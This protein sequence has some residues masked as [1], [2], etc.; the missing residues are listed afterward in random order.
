MNCV[1]TVVIHTYCFKSIINT[2]PYLGRLNAHI[3]EG[4]CAV[5]LNY[6]CNYLIIGVLEHHTHLLP[7]IEQPALIGSVYAVNISLALFGKVYSIKALGKGRFAR[8]VMPE[9][10]HELTFFDVKVNAL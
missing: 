6:R 5:L 2:P 3:L 7:Y 10:S 1:L 8:A 9:N 4:E